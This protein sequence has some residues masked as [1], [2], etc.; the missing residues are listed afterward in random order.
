MSAYAY[1]KTLRHMQRKALLKELNLPETPLELSSSQ[2]L[3]Q[4]AQ[5]A[6]T[7][8]SKDI[9]PMSNYF[10]YTATVGS[11]LLK[12]KDHEKTARIK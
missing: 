7:P 1:E 6:K 4:A 10:T 2:M 5:C 8:D 11:M 3:Y 12:S 9:S